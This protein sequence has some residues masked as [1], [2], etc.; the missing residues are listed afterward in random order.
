MSKFLVL[1]SSGFV[2]APLCDYLETFGHEVVRFDIRE[3]K[4][5]RHHRLP[6]TGVDRVFFLAWDVGGAKYLYH[7]GTQTNQLLWNT[8]IM[9]NVFMQLESTA[10]PFTFVSSAQASNPTTA[11]AAQ[12]RVGEIWTEQLCG[13]VVRLWNVYGAYERTTSRSHV[14]GDL[15]HSALTAGK[16][17]LMTHGDEQRRFCYIEDVVAA[18]AN[19]H[20]RAGPL[21]VVADKSSVF[22][23]ASM[24][25]T[26]LNVPVIRGED[27]GHPGNF[28]IAGSP[29]FCPTPLWDGLKKTIELYKEKRRGT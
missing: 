26:L 10:T 24:I 20:H 8:L 13:T 14:V 19:A 25:G 17:E 3:G 23:I 2:G 21:D 28:T 29:V 4:D 16:I 6:L 12:K 18:I 27:T 11:Y 5:C 9:S 15:I 1:G 7:P 22:D